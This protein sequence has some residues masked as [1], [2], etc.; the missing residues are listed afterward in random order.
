MQPS[1][2]YYISVQMPITYRKDLAKTATVRCE[3]AH[4]L[5]TL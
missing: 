2:D 4:P 5:L 1:F 3:G